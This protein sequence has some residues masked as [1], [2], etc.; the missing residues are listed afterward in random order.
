MEI[1]S[2]CEMRP[3]PPPV[4]PEHS[5]ACP[6]NSNGDLTFLRQHERLPEFL[7]VPGEESQATCCNSRQTTRFTCPR[8]MRPFLP[9]VP[10]E[11]SRVPSQNSRGGW[12]PFMQLKGPTIPVPTRDE[13]RGSRYKLRGA[14]CFPPY[15]EMRA[16]SLLQLKRNANFSCTTRGDLSHLLNFEWN[17]TDPASRKKDT[18][19]PLSSR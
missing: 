8:E 15:L 6:R 7:M 18:D 16:H 19:C 1:P 2:S 10:R 17:A 12:T 4:M 3:G 11:Q 5:R 13:S 9:A 14:K